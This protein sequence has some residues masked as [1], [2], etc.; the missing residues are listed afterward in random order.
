MITTFRKLSDLLDARERRNALFL[1]CIVLFQGLIEATPAAS[2]RPWNKTMHRR[3]KAFRLS[4]ASSRSLSLR[5]VVIMAPAP[6]VRQLYRYITKLCYRPSGEQ[7]SPLQEH[8][9]A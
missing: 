6:E 5:N 8:Y 2:I 1:L 4:R 3:N 9:G 7:L